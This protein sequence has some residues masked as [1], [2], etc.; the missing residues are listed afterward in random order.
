MWK[1]NEVE[2]VESKKELLKTFDFTDREI[3][4]KP[5]I[6]LIYRYSDGTLEKKVVTE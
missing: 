1:L 5:N 6:P 2:F 3:N 4:L